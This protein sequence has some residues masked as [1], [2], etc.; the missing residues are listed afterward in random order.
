MT[1]AKMVLSYGTGLTTIT[2]NGLD[3]AIDTL[4]AGRILLNGVDVVAQLAT[5]MSSIT[6]L[7]GMMA[8]M[9]TSLM[10]LQAS[11]TLQSA[12][13]SALQA[14]DAVQNASIATLAAAQSA[15]NVCSIIC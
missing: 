8:Q 2:Q 15:I 3:L 12:A 6:T 4:F 13:I 9:Q 10:L 7:N 5:A 11:G 14:T 1:G